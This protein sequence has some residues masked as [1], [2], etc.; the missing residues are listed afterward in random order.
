MSRDS[1]INQFIPLHFYEVNERE[2]EEDQRVI[3]L[4]TDMSGNI[5]ADFALFWVNKYTKK[6]SFFIDECGCVSAIAWATF[7]PGWVTGTENFPEK[8]SEQ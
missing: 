5:Q 6:G 4:Y 2:P 3:V 1:N 8:W 7:S